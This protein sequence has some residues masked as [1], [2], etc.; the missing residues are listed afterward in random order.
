MC[1]PHIILPQFV[2]FF[3]EEGLPT[4][5]DFVRCEPSHMV[6]SYTSCNTYIYDVET[7]KQIITLD[8]NQA[9]GESPGY[10]Y[11]SYFIMIVYK[12][13]A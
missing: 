10:L 1:L 2:N 3:P 4:S 7:A 5:V 6:A 9:G 11:L 13:T 12:I 8:T